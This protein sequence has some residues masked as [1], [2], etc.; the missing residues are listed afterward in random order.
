[1]TGMPWAASRRIV[2]MRRLGGG[3]Y[4]S[5]ARAVC[6]SQKVTDTETPTEARSFKSKSRSTSR[7]IKVDF[8][9]R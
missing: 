2:S 9:M 5:I 1:M 3:A 6:S 7:S 8:V 4:G